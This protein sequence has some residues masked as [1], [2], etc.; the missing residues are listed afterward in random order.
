MRKAD[1]DD[2]DN[3]FNPQNTHLKNVIVNVIDVKE[4]EREAAKWAHYVENYKLLG[5]EWGSPSILQRKISEKMTKCPKLIIS[6]H[7]TDY[8]CNFLTIKEKTW[9]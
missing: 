7:K 8:L 4:S 3:Y 6:N 9:T 1:N 5:I 2:N